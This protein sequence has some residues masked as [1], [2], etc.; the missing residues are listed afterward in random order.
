MNDKK[1]KQPQGIVVPSKKTSKEVRKQYGNYIVR[2]TD[3]AIKISA[4]SHIWSMEISILNPNFV[5][6]VPLFD[7][8]KADQ[9]LESF[10]T[11][12]FLLGNMMIDKGFMED[13][14]KIYNDRVNRMRDERKDIVSEEGS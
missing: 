1:K 2:I 11:L 13:F 4:V 3:E 8:K 6:L 5:L 7:D 14:I 10:F 12:N 9:Y